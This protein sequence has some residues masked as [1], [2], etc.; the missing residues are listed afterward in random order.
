M[1]TDSIPDL[2]IPESLIDKNMNIIGES[3]TN[4]II[5]GQKSGQSIFTIISGINVT[6]INLTLTNSSATNGGAILI[7]ALYSTKQHIHQ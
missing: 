2:T 3:Q 5:D 4:T 7:L 6:I 1:Q